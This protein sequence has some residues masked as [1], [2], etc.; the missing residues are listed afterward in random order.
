MLLEMLKS[1]LHNATVTKVEIDYEGSITIDAE[2]M[3]TVKILP[4]EKVLVANVTNGERFETYAIPA[5]CGSKEICLN[6]ATAHKGSIGDRVI[7]LSFTI[8]SQEE[9]ISHR[10]LVLVLGPGNKPI[11]GLKEV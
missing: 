1:K 11:G 2:L 7:I 10:P 4:Y 5:P 8:L 3:D 9:S 6:G